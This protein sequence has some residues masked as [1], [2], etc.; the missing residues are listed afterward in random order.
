ML[1]LETKSVHQW[2]NWLGTVQLLQYTDSY[3]TSWCWFIWPEK[4]CT[5]L[6]CLSKTKNK[7]HH[8]LVWSPVNTT[9]CDKAL[10]QTSISQASVRNLFST[11]N[12][13]R[14]H[15]NLCLIVWDRSNLILEYLSKG[16]VAKIFFLLLCIAQVNG[17]IVSRMSNCSQI[18]CHV[19]TIYG[20]NEAC[21]FAM[22]LTKFTRLFSIYRKT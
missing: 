15:Q 11:C 16:Q 3:L 17:G 22:V 7:L 20:K 6:Q 4:L 21:T 1:I 12:Y 2:K 9:S 18:A 14:V 5:K 8:L 10:K 19:I 13:C